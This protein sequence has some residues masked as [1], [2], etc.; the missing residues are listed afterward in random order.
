MS[1]LNSRYSFLITLAIV[2]VIGRCPL[3]EQEQIRANGLE[4][5]LGDLQLDEVSRLG[6]E[7]NRVIGSPRSPFRDP[8]FRR[9]RTLPGRQCGAEFHLQSDSPM[10]TRTRVRPVAS[11]IEPMSSQKSVFFHP[12]GRR[13]HAIRLRGAS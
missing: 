11:K 2:Y 13:F 8:A 9:A 6:C 5:I 4:L 12:V 10:T 1:E 3:G 7:V